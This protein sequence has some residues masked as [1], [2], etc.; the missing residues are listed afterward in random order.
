PRDRV[1]QFQGGGSLPVRVKATRQ[2]CSGGPSGS[3]T[4]RFRRAPVTDQAHA[5]DRRRR[6]GVESRAAGP[7]RPE[8]V[9]S[10]PHV[11]HRPAGVGEQGDVLASRE[12]PRQ[13]A[14]PRAVWASEYPAGAIDDHA[15]RVD[16]R[17][18]A[19]N[20]ERREQQHLPRIRDRK[21]A[22][23]SRP[24]TRR[25]EHGTGAPLAVDGDRVIGTI[26]AEADERPAVGCRHDTP[27]PA[28]IESIDAAGNA[29]IERRDRELEPWVTTDVEERPVEAAHDP[30]A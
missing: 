3:Q 20:E 29:P 19:V 26:R 21:G 28:R 6:I 16:D 4:G 12:E 17:A 22:A 25:K 13:R 14:L 8:Y 30:V 10:T 5:A 11:S 7:R 15:G 18:V 23:D 2:E 24:Q 1:E 27:A 9:P